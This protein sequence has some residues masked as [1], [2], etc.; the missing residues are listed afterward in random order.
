MAGRYTW[1]AAGSRQAKTANNIDMIYLSSLQ[2]GCC[3]L[4]AISSTAIP[5]A[6]EICC[7]MRPSSSCW[8]FRY[9]IF[10][11]DSRPRVFLPQ[12]FV[13]AFRK[14]ERKLNAG[15]IQKKKQK[16][17]YPH[18]QKEEDIFY[19]RVYHIRRTVCRPLTRL[20]CVGHPEQSK[21]EDRGRR[22]IRHRNNQQLYKYYVQLFPPS[23]LFCFVIPPK[24]N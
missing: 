13:T 24:D 12:W 9:L 8:L 14:K 17:S 16:E 20:C 5:I 21:T 19:I 11:E 4:G 2:V 23:Y 3:R 22:V 7:W 15:R 6:R 18:K 1:H 10:W